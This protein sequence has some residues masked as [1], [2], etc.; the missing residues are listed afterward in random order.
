[1]TETEA[2]RT[3]NK[4]RV[5]IDALKEKK[6]TDI[7]TIDLR[8]TGNAIFDLFVICQG[9]STTQVDALSESVYRKVKKELNIAAHHVEGKNNSLWVLMDYSDIVVHIFL[10]EQRKFYNLEDLWADGVLDR[11]ED[12]L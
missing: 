10:E 1:M 11:I 9:N 3:D 5:I 8:E 7:V 6:G 4:L 12:D 2:T